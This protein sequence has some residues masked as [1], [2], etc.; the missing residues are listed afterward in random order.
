MLCYNK[1]MKHLIEKS[2]LEPYKSPIWEF[3]F[4]GLRAGVLDIETTGLSPER[5][6]FILGGLYD[7]QT[8]EM[9]QVLAESRAEEAEV[10][11]EFN[12]LLQNL[13]VVVTYNGRNFDV[14]F[15]KKRL[16]KAVAEGRYPWEGD[17]EMLQSLYDLDLFLV[18]QGHSPIRKFVPNL[19]QKTIENYMGLWETRTDEISGAESVDLFNHYEKTKNP[20]AEA[21]ILL[22]N[23]DDVKQLTK[24]TKVISKCDMHRA[25][26]SMGFPAGVPGMKTGRPKLQSD[27]LHIQGTV[28]GKDAGLCMDYIGYEFN[29]CPV[30]A[31]FSSAEETFQFDVPVTRSSGMTLIDLDSLGLCM[32]EFEQ[33]P[34]CESG[35]LIIEDRNGLRHMEINHFTKAFIKKFQE[36]AL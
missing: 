34:T 24:L 9:H 11:R 23:S 22:H 15:L 14:P 7:C 36:E 19:R 17:G 8:H 12:N 27:G 29:G 2:D 6:K 3:Y 20:D 32:E 21:K 35:F 5:N 28:V 30:C 13:D 31:R 4:G 16:S 25:M 26:M 33:Y 10:L 18:V 1:S